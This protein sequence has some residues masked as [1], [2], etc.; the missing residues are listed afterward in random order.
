MSR[1]YESIQAARSYEIKTMRAEPVVPFVD[2]RSQLSPRTVV[3]ALCRHFKIFSFAVFAII[4]ITAVGTF[5]A[6]KQYLSQMK[7]IVQNARENIAVSP[8]RTTP[9]NTNTDVTEEQVN[10]ELEILRSHDVIDPVADPAWTKLSAQ[11]RTPAAVQQHEKLITSFEKRLGTDI[12]R[13]TNVINVSLSG[14]SPEQAQN[15]LQALAASYIAEHRRL[16]R[17]EG[18]SEFFAAEADRTRKAW[19]DATE[20]LVKFQQEHQ[21]LSVADSSSFLD[22]QIHETEEQLFDTN[23]S[24]READAQVSETSRR[25]Q[26]LP[27][28]QVT[29]EKSS[30]NQLSA[31]Q[32]ATLA[33]ELQNKRIALA[34]NYK[35]TDRLIQELDQQIATVQAALHEEKTVPTHEQTTDVDPAWQQLHNNYVQD[36][37]TRQ[38]LNQ[39][40]ASLNTRLDT[41]KHSLGDLQNVTAQFN[42]LQAQANELKENY[43]LYLQKRDQAQIEDAMD[44]HKLLNVAV[45]QQPTLSFLPVHPRPKLNLA[46]G[47][48]TALFLGVCVVYFAETSRRTIATPRELESLSRYPVLATVPHV[49]L[50]SYAIAGQLGEAK[51]TVT[52]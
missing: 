35:P 43:E 33:V 45:A 4:V 28:R 8:A 25:L 40:R 23:A 49:S 37:I 2:A 16:Q 21:I 36:Q 1:Y 10:S 44:E 42:N 27:P 22:D 17:P 12:V 7:F 34:A 39:R 6:R 11:Q 31:Q 20:Q 47:A 51:Q 26:A 14:D 30:P 52:A 19:N 38:G 41:L 46:L 9:S 32:L 24:L 29:Q 50:P 48:L 13:R 18:A 5:I 3:E 15:Q